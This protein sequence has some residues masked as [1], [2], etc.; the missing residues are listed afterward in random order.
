LQECLKGK[1]KVWVKLPTPPF[2]ISPFWN[3]TSLVEQWTE[4]TSSW[5]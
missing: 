3:S 4:L 5:A 2:T 1:R